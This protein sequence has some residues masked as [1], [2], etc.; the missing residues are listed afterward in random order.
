[1][2]KP[3]KAKKISEE[4]LNNIKAEVLGQLGSVNDTIDENMAKV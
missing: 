2:K 4:E 3:N 1:M